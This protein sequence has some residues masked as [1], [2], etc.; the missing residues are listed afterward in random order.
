MSAK[1]CSSTLA[2]SAKNLSAEWQ[3]TQVHWRDAKA[4]QFQREYLDELPSLIGKSREALDELDRLLRK[5][6]SDCE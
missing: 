3:E 4:A 6:R 5:V 1:G 2:Q